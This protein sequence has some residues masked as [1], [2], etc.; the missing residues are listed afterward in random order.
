VY[1]VVLLF[2]AALGWLA[3]NRLDSK[4]TVFRSA[5]EFPGIPSHSDPAV[6]TQIS[7]AVAAVR[8]SPRNGTAWGHLGMVLHAYQFQ[9]EARICFANAQQLNQ[10]EPRWPYFEGVILLAS[11]PEAGLQKLARAVELCPSTPD[12]PRLQYARGL[13]EY[14]RLD[15]AE[16]Q[17][18]ELF[19]RN[20]SH[21]PALL[22]LARIKH[23]RGQSQEATDY[24]KRC[25]ESPYAA[26]TAYLLLAAVQAKTGN[27][28]AA[29]AATAFANNLPEDKSW[30]E[31]Y[32]DEIL[33]L[34]VGSRQL[35][36]HAER[37]LKLNNLDDA[38]KVISRLVK[39][40]SSSPQTWLLAGRLH[41]ERKE[42]V[43]AT[44]AFR[45]HLALAPE[46]VNG[47]AQL[48]MALLCEE[49]YPEAIPMLERAVQ[50]KPDFA[51]GHF[52]LGFARARA[53][54]GASAVAA[55]RDAIRCSPN[56]VE[57]YITLADLLGQMGE[58]EEALSLLQRARVIDPADPRPQVV[59]ERI[60]KPRA[61][62]TFEQHP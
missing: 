43:A 26:Q 27:A 32:T 47:C 40:Y 10:T 4:S 34:Q 30:P 11:N 29:Q 16:E 36:D 20:R 24:V 14:G 46:S 42:C 60:K 3:F 7:E 38:E 58:V 41:L 6:A 18:R 28:Q 45:R 49:K 15:Q 52:N 25:L 54:Q 48:G 61:G 59:L 55:F 33:A 50:L 9:E 35:V 21:A 2:V 62:L 53:G 17:F 39:G 31:P 44:E 56:F 57:P 51:Q 23:A 37:A 5:P 12:T 13:L 8:N 1:V 19:T 22:G